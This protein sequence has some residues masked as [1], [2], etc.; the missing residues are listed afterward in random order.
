[1]TDRT[2]DLHPIS[3]DPTPD[4]LRLLLEHRPNV[5]AGIGGDTSFSYVLP[6]SEKM[7]QR[8]VSSLVG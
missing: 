7:F 4:D 3:F 6:A 5:I 2:P 8:P 1:M